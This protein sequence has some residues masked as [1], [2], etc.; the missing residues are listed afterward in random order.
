M[1][2]RP[3]RDPFGTRTRVLKRVDVGNYQKGHL[4]GWGLDVRDPTADRRL[5]ELCLSI[6]PEQFLVEGEPRALARAAFADRLPPEILQEKRSGLQASD[7]HEGF[8][9][10]RDEIA[11]EV[12]RFASI[13]ATGQVLDDEMLK[14]LLSHIPDGDWNSSKV[15]SLYRLALLRGLSAGHFVRKATGSNA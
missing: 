1:N 2:F 14:R 6:P 13:E 5:V 9:A 15:S 11:E 3:R 7:W 10:A 4:A 12:E 8:A